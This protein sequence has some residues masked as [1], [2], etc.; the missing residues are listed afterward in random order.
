MMTT[1]IRRAA[2]ASYQWGMPSR[3]APA[4]R[5]TSRPRAFRWNSG[6]P[7]AEIRRHH[8]PTLLVA[9]PQGQPHGVPILSLGTWHVLPVCYPFAMLVLAPAGQHNTGV[10]HE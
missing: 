1:A 3:T 7:A 4:P 5:D 9:C 10:Q 8:R 6:T 2:P